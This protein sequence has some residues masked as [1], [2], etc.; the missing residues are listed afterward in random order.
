MERRKIIALIMMALILTGIAFWGGERLLMRQSNI[1]YYDVASKVEV[2]LS[3]DWSSM[4]YDG[5]FFQS[6]IDDFN[7]K[8]SDMVVINDCRQK[9]EYFEYLRM[10]IS[11]GNEPDIFISYPGDNVETYITAS[12]VAA[13]NKYL[14]E[15]EDWYESFD[16]SV[17]RSVTVD[18]NVYALPLETIY[19]AMFVNVDVLEQCGLEVPSTYEEWMEMIPVLK[20][21]GIVPIAF[22]FA[23]NELMLYQA[24]VAKLGGRFYSENIV[25]NGTYNENYI[26]AA[27]YLKELYQLRAFPDNLFTITE[28]ECENLFLEK[29]AAFIVQDSHFV[30]NIGDLDENSVI[31]CSMPSFEN[32]KA[33]EKFAL[34]GLGKNNL[35]VSSKAMEKKEEY[36]LRFLK[37]MTSEEVAAKLKD[38]LGALSAVNPN[39]NMFR[40]NNAYVNRE[41]LHSLMETVNFISNYADEGK[42]SELV[43]NMPAFLENKIELEDIL[44][45]TT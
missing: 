3:S 43:E 12:K 29:K 14:N 20:G 9:D 26:A 11:S 2:R 27:T 35:F 44:Y 13:L 7:E 40:D 24:I 33:A 34:Y 23:D 38:E 15:D 22:H 4:N 41:F 6:L 17:W 21:E 25:E 28:N 37:Y 36:I 10:D 5:K 18:G 42:W 32:A 45:E 1:T 8:N 31:I 16:K 30:I 39:E 19:A